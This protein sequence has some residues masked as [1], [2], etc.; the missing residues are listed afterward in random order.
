MLGN[1][2]RSVVYRYLHSFNYGLVIAEY[3]DAFELH[4]NDAKC[5]FDHTDDRDDR[6]LLAL[7]YRDLSDGYDLRTI[8]GFGAESRRSY[9]LPA[10]YRYSGIWVPVEF[11]T[12][13]RHSKRHSN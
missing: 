9:D 13:N 3:R 1:D 11:K 10:S 7:N 4:W 5:V 2:L 12:H 6:C 8:Y